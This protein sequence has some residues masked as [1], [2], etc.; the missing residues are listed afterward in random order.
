MRLPLTDEQKSAAT[1]TDDRVYI[2]ASPG[3]G[4]TTVATE[5]YGVC[6]YMRGDSERGVLALSFARSARGELYERVMRRWGSAAMRWPHKVWTLDHLHAALVQHLLASGALRWPGG[7]TQLEIVDTWRGHAGSRPL[8]AG[9]YRCG[10]YVDSGQVRIGGTTAAPA[11]HAFSAAKKYRERLEDGLCTHE[12]IRQVLSSAIQKGSPLE[13]IVSDFLKGTI[14]SLIVDEVFDGNRLDLRIVHAAA[15]KGV[16]T[17]LIGDPWQALYAFRGAAP[18]LVPSVV[19]ALGFTACPITESFRFQTGAMQSMAA[20]LRLRQPV[21]VGAGASDRCDVVLASEW[22]RLWGCTSVLP[23]SFGQVTNRVDAAMAILLD[24]VVAQRFKRLSSFGPDAEVMLGLDETVLRAEG[25]T[26]LPSV[27]ATLS[28]GAA[29]A[30]ST[31]FAELR[32]VLLSMGSN[33][34]TSLTAPKMAVRYDRLRTLSERAALADVI[35]GLTIHQA[36]GREWRR[37]GVALSDVEV[38]RLASGLDET[39]EADRTL[40]V[41]L[42]RARE[43]TCA[44]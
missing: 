42:T 4:K 24:H 15:T 31:A 44:V 33:N 40:Y 34:I 43:S 8:P 2:E 41:G 20:T 37:V 28:S 6:R 16:P 10:L 19:T 36:K 35:P 32:E 11:T 18:N 39:R 5:R 17:T 21:S 38:A 25:P 26:Q 7:H 30:A 13:G 9:A 14:S 3:S 23:L 22:A 12:E 29:D 1:C 27:M